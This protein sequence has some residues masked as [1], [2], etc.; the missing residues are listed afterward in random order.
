MCTKEN[1]RIPIHPITAKFAPPRLFLFTCSTKQKNGT[2]TV[3]RGLWHPFQSRFYFGMRASM[4]EI[5]SRW[6][7]NDDMRK[8]WNTGNPPIK[9]FERGACLGKERIINRPIGKFGFVVSIATRTRR[10]TVRTHLQFTSFSSVWFWI[11]VPPCQR[12]NRFRAVKVRGAVAADQEYP[13]LAG[14]LR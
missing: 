5:G 6:F 2:Q 4:N 13:S 8:C 11:F 1:T 7:D 14:A 9:L 3:S 12:G 10:L